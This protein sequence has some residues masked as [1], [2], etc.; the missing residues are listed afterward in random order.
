M[1]LNM[2]TVNNLKNNKNILFKRNKVTREFLLSFFPS[3]SG[4]GE[5]EVNGFILIKQFTNFIWNVAIYTK[6]AYLK[7]K[8][9]RNKFSGI[10]VNKT[11]GN[12]ESESK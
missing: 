10:F 2:Q 3:E 11:R 1:I 4:Y 8:E 9:H 5:K 6:N 7:K 12:S